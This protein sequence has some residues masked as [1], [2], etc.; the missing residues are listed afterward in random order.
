VRSIYAGWARGDFSSTHWADSQIDFVITDGPAP[1]RWTGVTGMNEGW[2]GVL[3]AFRDLRAEAE[4]YRDIGGGRVLALAH[5][6][7][8]GRVSEVELAETL[9]KHAAVFH[10]QAG[11]VIRLVVYFDRQLALA[12]LGLASEAS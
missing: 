5:S 1:G 12:D 3:G 8:R 6:N 11:K 7:A 9:T 10:I 4:E 2:R